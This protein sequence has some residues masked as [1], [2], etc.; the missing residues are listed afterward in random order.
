MKRLPQAAVHRD[1]RR[2]LRATAR[3]VVLTAGTL[4]LSLLPRLM[5]RQ[6]DA[7]VRTFVVPSSNPGSGG[8]EA[9]VLSIVRASGAGP[10][11]PARVVVFDAGS[12]WPGV[13]AEDHVRESWIYSRVPWSGAWQFLRGVRPTDRFVWIAADTIDGGHDRLLLRR[14]VAVLAAVAER[15][16][17]VRVVNFSVRPG[18][19][20]EPSVRRLLRMSDRSVVRDELSAAELDR[21]RVPYTDLAPDCAY[22]LSSADASTTPRPEREM[23]IL[24]NVAGHVVDKGGRSDVAE[25]M[26]DAVAA[27]SSRVPGLEW[28]LIVH[29][30]RGADGDGPQTERLASALATRGVR[31]EMLPSGLAPDEIRRLVAGSLLVVTSRMH[32]AVAA[33]SEGVVPV[34][35]TYFHQKFLAQTRLFELPEWLLLEGRSV[36]PETLRDAILRALDDRQVLEQAVA[37]HRSAVR[38]SSRAA[39]AAYLGE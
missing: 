13:P 37:H 24:L 16:A 12:L 5:P 38:S 39:L 14:T 8:E 33:L 29:D 18:A 17:S 1:R 10:R 26:A 20:L 3:R 35:V 22:S 6:P 21:Q 25:V 11:P 32:L 27:V 36:T 15:G 34:C 9:M 4:S 30:S 7:A 28:A 23:R 19:T 31:A 2:A